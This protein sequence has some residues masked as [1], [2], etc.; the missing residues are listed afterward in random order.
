MTIEA[1]SDELR[2]QANRLLASYPELHH[3]WEGDEL[4]FPSAHSDGYDVTLQPDAHGI[5]LFTSLGA[6]EHLE[7]PPLEAVQEALGLARDLLS[8]D[9]RVRELTAAG[10]GYRWVLERRDPDGWKTESQTGLLLWNYFGPRGERI[11]HNR[12]LPGRLAEGA[13]RS[14]ERG[15]SESDSAG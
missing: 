13:N 8:P 7:G 9:M 14:G 5:I 11:Y 6:H 3:E 1:Y 10:R 15:N 12:Q 4:V 2:R